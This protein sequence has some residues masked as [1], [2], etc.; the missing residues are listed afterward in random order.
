MDAFPRHSL[1]E[2]RPRS[3]IFKL[4]IVKCVQ[5][6]ASFPWR[7]TLRGNEIIDKALHD[8]GPGVF[9]PW[10]AKVNLRTRIHFKKGR[11]RDDFA[12]LEDDSTSATLVLATLGSHHAT[13]VLHGLSDDQCA[14]LENSIGI[15][16]DEVDGAGDDTVTVKLTIVVA[17]E[18]VLVPIHVNVVEDGLI[19]GGTD[20]Y[21]LVLMGGPA[22]FSMPMSL[23]MNSSPLM[24]AGGNNAQIIS[25][26]ATAIG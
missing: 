2:I 20:S 23:A 14:I 22:V 3:A 9:L 13:L 16:E 12:I 24:A 4:T 1:G 8:N 25:Q 15:S 7:P 10:T 11:I 19:T 5:C 17:V 18:G 21:G 6:K 26:P